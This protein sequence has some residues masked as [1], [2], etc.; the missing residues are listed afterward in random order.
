MQP[1]DN[2]VHTTSQLGALVAFTKRLGSLEL[3]WQDCLKFPPP[4]VVNIFSL[5]ISEK[6][7]KI[8]IFKQCV[9]TFAWKINNDMKRTGLF[10]FFNIGSQ[11]Q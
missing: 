2:Y 6:A 8:T 7:R 11:D 9:K 5:I 1:A 10:F 4:L 3:E